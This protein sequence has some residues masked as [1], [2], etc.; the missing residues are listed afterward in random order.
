MLQERQLF[1]K[2]LEAAIL[3]VRTQ[4][5]HQLEMERSVLIPLHC[6]L[7]QYMYMYNTIINCCVYRLK[8][9]ELQSLIDS[10]KKQVHTL[11]MY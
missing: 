7:S 6:I 5:E 3:Q 8:S 2:E 9:S 10:H 4:Y 1:R 11:W